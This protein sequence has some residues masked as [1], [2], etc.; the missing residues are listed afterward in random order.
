MPG[1]LIAL[2]VVTAFQPGLAQAQ[3]L[4]IRFDEIGPLGRF[5]L[6]NACWPMSL[7]VE[8]L[9]D[10]AKA[11][12]L[13][14][15]R[16]RTAAESRLREAHLYAGYSNSENKT[17]LYIDIRVFCF[18]LWFCL[19]YNKNLID[20]AYG[21]TVTTTAW[22]TGSLETHGNDSGGIIQLLSEKLNRFI[23]AYLLVNEKDCPR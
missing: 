10:D 1:L 13:M 5:K 19:A 6:H 7:V 8:D 20:P 2:A 3:D 12:G 21:M 11:I 22:K 15:D 18:A 14:E 23:V 17:F 4:D 9:S 16:I